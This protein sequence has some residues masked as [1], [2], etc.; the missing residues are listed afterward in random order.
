MRAL[1]SDHQAD[2]GRAGGQRNE[3]AAQGEGSQ[4]G[5]RPEGGGQEGGNA[6]QG[7]ST[8]GAASNEPELP[9]LSEQITLEELWDTLGECLS[10]LGRTS[11]S[12]AV[13][14][15]QP[16]VEAFFLVHGTEKQESGSTQTQGEQPRSGHRL[17]SVSSEIMP[18]SPGHSPQAPRVP[19][20]RCQSHP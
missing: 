13:L 5:N 18:A 4:D 8:S 16:A 20:G 10:E 7:A 1:R 3:P 15:L 14:V 17:S 6:Q 9:L 2:H 12:H 11:D 19:A